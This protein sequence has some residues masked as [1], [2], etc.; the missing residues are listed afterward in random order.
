MQ[1]INCCSLKLKTF[2]LLR[3]MACILFQ[4]NRGRGLKREGR[5][6][7]IGIT[8]LG[9]TPSFVLQESKFSKRFREIMPSS[10]WHWAWT[11]QR[12]VWNTALL[13]IVACYTHIQQ[14]TSS[15]KNICHFRIMSTTA[16]GISYANIIFYSQSTD[17]FGIKINLTFCNNFIDY[18]R[19][20]I[21]TAQWS[22][23]EG[24]GF[25]F[26]CHRIFQLI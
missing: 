2:S 10:L 4:L 19:Q 26:R 16:S 22:L 25:D 13:Q 6:A 5:Q 15:R 17:T 9:L 1:A 20:I 24:R 21:N 18:E 23:M 11:S 8:N 3:F 14:I 7:E 12:Y